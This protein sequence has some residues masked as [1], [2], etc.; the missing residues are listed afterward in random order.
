MLVVYAYFELIYSKT[1]RYE[2]GG[3][4]LLGSMKVEF[5]FSSI[6]W[7]KLISPKRLC[8]KICSF[9]L[10]V[11]VSTTKRFFLKRA[12]VD[13]VVIICHHWLHGRLST[14]QTHYI[15]EVEYVYGEYHRACTQ[16]HEES[17]FILDLQASDSNP[18]NGNCDS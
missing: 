9:N 17:F 7:T 11:E 16:L 15:Q 8:E 5:R 6:N 14:F 1:A 13:P 4:T 18:Q 2:L 3:K 10:K 12:V